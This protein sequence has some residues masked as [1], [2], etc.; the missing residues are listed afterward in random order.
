MRHRIQIHLAIHKTIIISIIA[1]FFHF[2]GF[3][4]YQPVYR[5]DTFSVIYDWINQVDTNLVIEHVQH[6]QD[7]LTRDC[8]TA[9]A[10]AAQNWIKDQYDSLDLAV[11]LQDF[12]LGN[13]NPSDNVLATMTGQ[14]LPDEYVILGGH[15]DSWTASFLAPGADDNASGTSGVLEVARI[16][17]QYKFQR[18]IIFCAFSAE[19]YG[20]VGSEAYVSKCAYEDLNILGYINMDMIGYREPGNYLH[21]DMIAPTSAQA[22]ADFYTAVTAIYL[23]DFPIEEGALSGGD[24]DHTSFNNHGY[25]GIFPFEDDE[26]YSPYIHTTDDVV[27]TSFNSPLLAG[28]LIQAGLASIA[29]LA[30]PYDPVGIKD[31]TVDRFKIKIYP[32]PAHYTLNIEAN[33][34]EP[35]HFELFSLQGSSLALGEFRNN[36]CIDV[37]GIT[38]GIYVL[39]IFNKE[40]SQHR[41]LIIK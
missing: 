39:K 29:T 24:S 20:L 15:Y 14:L 36:T 22:L 31:L 17:S 34:T 12:P 25:Q 11:E 30:I 19:E 26:H 28:K 40:V 3:P 38:P 16:L 35:V 41:K 18:S 23:P 33:T 9:N 13:K 37:T 2:S 27:G 1:V 10:V 8:L 6:L 32:N 4:Q 7:Y 21:S 5:V